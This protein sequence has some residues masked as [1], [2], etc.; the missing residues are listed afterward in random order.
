[1]V[2]VGKVPNRTRNL[3]SFYASIACLKTL[4]IALPFS[5]AVPVANLRPKAV[6]PACA[7][8]GYDRIMMVNLRSL[9]MLARRDAGEVFKITTDNVAVGLLVEV[10]VCNYSRIHYFSVS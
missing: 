6:G 1:M 10:C 7:H 5:F 4:D 2:D 9:E 8:R 3:T